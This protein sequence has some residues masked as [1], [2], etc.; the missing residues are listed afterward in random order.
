MKTP[1][2]LILLCVIA[3]GL[4]ASDSLGE[5]RCAQS[6]LGPGVW[7]R[8]IEVENH[9]RG[10]RYPAEVYALVFEFERILWFYTDTDGTQSISQYIGRAAQDEANLGPLLMEV[11]P[12]FVAWRV[13]ADGPTAAPARGPLKNGCVIESIV[14]LRRRL[15]LGADITRPKLLFYYVPT[16][17]GLHGHTV[18][19]FEAGGSFTVV[20]PEFPRAPWRIARS[21]APTAAALAGAMRDD[22]AKARWLPVDDEAR[23]YSNLSASIGSS[24]DARRAG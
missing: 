15:M 21:K 16:P 13:V 20:D 12:G 3:A 5:A 11:D 24:R 18:L 2:G 8:V 7:S 10:S 4:H 14:L 19:A 17:A 9:T 1:S 22:V 6:L 23:A